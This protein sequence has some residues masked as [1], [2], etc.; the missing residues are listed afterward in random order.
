MDFSYKYAAERCRPPRRKRT[1]I[2]A[3]GAGRPS[4]RRCSGWPYPEPSCSEGM[5]LGEKSHAAFLHAFLPPSGLLY[6][7]QGTVHATGRCD[8]VG[9]VCTCFYRKKLSNGKS[10][11]FSNGKSK[12]PLFIVLNTAAHPT[13]ATSISLVPPAG[14]ACASPLPC[15][16]PA[17]WPHSISRPGCSAQN[18][19]NSIAANLERWRDDMRCSSTSR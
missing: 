15:H 14:P 12:A 19:E 3:V 4:R 2:G 9:S 6:V 17:S 7:Q 16:L 10:A 1:T 5:P 8:L 18:C 13:R 11:R